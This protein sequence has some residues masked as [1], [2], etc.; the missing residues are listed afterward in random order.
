MCGLV[1]CG[2]AQKLEEC[3]GQA[4]MFLPASSAYETILPHRL[5]QTGSSRF[6]A[7]CGIVAGFVWIPR[8]DC[9]LFLPHTPCTGQRSLHIPCAVLMIFS[10]VTRQISQLQC[11][12][13]DRRQQ[14]AG[15]IF[16]GYQPKTPRRSKQ[17]N[18]DMLISWMLPC[19][20]L[21]E[22]GKSEWAL[23]WLNPHSLA[24][25]WHRLK[26]GGRNFS[27]RRAA[28]N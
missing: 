22:L 2:T 9:S 18:S 11:R 7:C 4:L 8:C 20:L 26:P 28:K 24:L 1:G 5:L 3:S 13:T 19:N 21:L 10:L 6:V 23:S 27:R 14:G 15:E 16:A 17:Y 25:S 12:E